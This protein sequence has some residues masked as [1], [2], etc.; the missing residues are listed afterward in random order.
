MRKRIPRGTTFMSYVA[1]TDQPTKNLRIDARKHKNQTSILNSSQEIC[2]MPHTAGNG[3]TD[4]QLKKKKHNTFC[5]NSNFTICYDDVIPAKKIN[6][7]V[8]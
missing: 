2:T 5:N 6:S 4:G 7:P 3:Q 8:A 1:S